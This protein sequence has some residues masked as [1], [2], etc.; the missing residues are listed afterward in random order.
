MSKQTKLFTRKK[1][2]KN[3]IE[4]VDE[5]FI[6]LFLFKKYVKEDPADS[7]NILYNENPKEFINQLTK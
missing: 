5:I 1:K 3:I 2:T 7:G 6:V 4:K